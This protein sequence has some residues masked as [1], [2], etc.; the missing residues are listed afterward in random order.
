MYSY[1][2]DSA[3]S[4]QY[5]SISYNFLFKS[6][7]GTEHYWLD[8]PL[9]K[10]FIHTL[11]SCRQR[12]LLLLL[13]STIFKNIGKLCHLF[14]ETYPLICTVVAIYKQFIYKLVG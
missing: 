4:V 5:F 11:K 8:I 3:Y 10:A 6:I 13:K 1:E 7:F 2:D 12:R 14:G 9:F